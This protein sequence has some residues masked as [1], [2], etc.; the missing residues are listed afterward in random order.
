METRQYA[1]DV[2]GTCRLAGKLRPPPADLTDEHPGPELRPATPGRPPGLEIGRGGAGAA[3][4]PAA[5]GLRDPDQRRR[6]LHGFANHELQA[7]ELFAWALLA[8]PEAPAPFRRGLLDILVEEQG[9]VRLY[10]ER[11]AEEGGRLEDHPLSGYFWGKVG[12]LAAP[13]HFVSAMSLTFE[14]ANLDHSREYAA[15]A[16]AAGDERTAAVLERIHRE[17]IGHVGF[18]WHWLNRFRKPGQSMWEAYTA[19]LVWPLHP[20]LARGRSFDRGAREAAGMEPAFL[21]RLA[22]CERGDTSRPRSDPGA[23]QP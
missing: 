23:G 20:A 11:L 8:Y 21:E 4:I 5:A 15:A 10:L 14:S 13:A 9:H 1:L 18:G 7:V 22:Q 17:E 3:R 16:R 6:I 19:H 12:R 2:V